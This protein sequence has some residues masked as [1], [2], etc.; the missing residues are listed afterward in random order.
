MT[1]YSPEFK[2]HVVNDYL[3]GTLGYASLAKKYQIPDKKQI[4]TWVRKYKQNG[5]SGLESKEKQD[6]RGEF[7]LNILNYMKK[8]GASDSMTTNH[9]GISD[10]GTLPIRN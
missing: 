3:K 10:T 8:T 9:F 6:Y 5:K 4:Y 7:K 1:K 2:L